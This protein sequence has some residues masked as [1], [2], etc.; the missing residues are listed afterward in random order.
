MLS[1]GG[2][3]RRC[4][5]LPDRSSN[6]MTAVPDGLYCG[7]TAKVQVRGNGSQFRLQMGNTIYDEM[8][9]AWGSVDN[10]GLL[11]VE[12]TNTSTASSP[13]LA[14]SAKFC[15]SPDFSTV[16]WLSY[17]PFSDFLRTLNNQ[18]LR[19]S[20]CKP[21]GKLLTGKYCGSIPE[22]GLTTYLFVSRPQQGYL[23]FTLV[24]YN[25]SAFNKAGYFYQWFDSQLTVDDSP[26]VS[27]FFENVNS[28]S[29]NNFFSTAP[30]ISNSSTF[31]IFRVGPSD[32][33]SK[34]NVTFNAPIYSYSKLGAGGTPTFVMVKSFSNIQ[35][36]AC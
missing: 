23:T 10:S 36:L 16:M 9:Q 26:A 13:V 21:F 12:G 4:V 32:S 2:V 17:D 25:I 7:T 24:A 15:A 34:V 6:R 8:C 19:R 1:H 35:H 11:H 30:Q 5:E 31:Q 3:L 18:P 33:S 28:N 27:G 14:V 29:V 20:S 22:V